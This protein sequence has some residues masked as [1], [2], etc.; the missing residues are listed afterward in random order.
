MRALS[1][2]VTTVLFTLSLSPAQAYPTRGNIPAEVPSGYESSCD[3]AHKLTTGDLMFASDYPD[4]LTEAERFLL[5]GCDMDRS[6][7]TYR[8]TMSYLMQTLSNYYGQTGQ[9]P[10]A[11]TDE[12]IEAAWRDSGEHAVA[13]HQELLRSPLTGRYPRLDATTFSRGDMYVALVSTEE[14]RKMAETIPSLHRL[15]EQASSYNQR[16]SAQFITPVF[17]FRFY[18]ETE[19]IY[20]GLH[21]SY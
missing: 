13:L 16:E 3:V 20:T 4:Y 14:Q 12:V 7:D 6:R 1:I 15:L 18:G 9:I 5:F 11:L 8:G 10:A 17:Y 2:L 19:V 21:Y